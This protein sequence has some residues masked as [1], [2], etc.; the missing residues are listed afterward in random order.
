MAPTS[1][2][3]PGMSY[4]G[5]ARVTPHQLDTFERACPRRLHLD[6]WQDQQSN[7]TEFHRWDIRL[8]L[9][10]RAGAA[11]RTNR[12]LTPEDLTVPPFSEPEQRALFAQ[13]AESYLQHFGDQA[14]HAVDHGITKATFSPARQVE[15]GGAI[16]L[17]LQSADGRF[18]LRHLELWRRELPD[19]PL[20]A[21]EIRL[22][23]LRLSRQLAGQ[24][25]R[26][27]RVDL[28]EHQRTE[29][30]IDI[31]AELPGLREWFDDRLSRLR[32][33]AEPSDA[34]SGI[35]CGRCA[36]V[37]TCPAHDLSTSQVEEPGIVALT[38]TIASDWSRC[39]RLYRLKYQ[40]DLPPS[41]PDSGSTHV[42]LAVHDL[43]YRVHASGS[44]A[45]TSHLGGHAGNDELDEFGGLHGYLERHRRR[46]PGDSDALGHEYEVARVSPFPTKP[47]FII[48]TRID[49]LWIHDGILD[50]RD[51]KTGRP[52]E[53]PV[54]TSLAA[55]IQAFA[56]A[57]IAAERGLRLRI[58]HE[59]LAEGVEEDPDSFE[60]DEEQL[61]AIAEELHSIARAIRM[62]QDF[63][64][65]NDTAICSRCE[66]RSICR[67]SAR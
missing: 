38:P 60:P 65:V 22:A 2:H 34:R 50:A 17:L 20:D 41:D 4:P 19:D 33:I 43:L 44:C 23:V 28:F 24:K 56:L 58:R 61:T 3:S 5:L 47:W 9:L 18:E 21:T 39:R 46:C 7:Q 59:Y 48:T 49:A 25:L 54:G 31:D 10:A 45:D 14:V 35:Q 12:H 53:E 36:H 8:A 40:L 52:T 63:T 51:Y 11:H 66:Y 1:L 64:G 6:H 37:P 55:R 16:D 29:R 32:A 30:T 27:C 57:P 42:G 26:I 13:A 15:I 67:D 62:E